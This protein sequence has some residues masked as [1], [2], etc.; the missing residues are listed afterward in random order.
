MKLREIVLKLGFWIIQ[1]LVSPDVYR[2]KMIQNSLKRNQKNNKLIYIN[3]LIPNF[4]YINNKGKNISPELK[5][6]FI[7]NL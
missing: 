7:L 2:F 4:N 3:T 6:N 1:K 5:V